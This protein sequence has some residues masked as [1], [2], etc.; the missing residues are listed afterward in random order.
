MAASTKPPGRP[1]SGGT[2]KPAAAAPPPVPVAA[3]GAAPAHTAKRARVRRPVVLRRRPRPL[4]GGPVALVRFMRANRMLN[5]RYGRLAL[6]WWVLKLRWRGRLRTDGLC[7]IAPGVKFEIGPHAQVTLGRWCWIGRGTKV[8]VH[9]GTLEIGAKTVLGEE[10]T[11]SAFQK[12]T[13]GRECII[14]DRTMFIDFDHG[15][16]EVER[17]I[18]QQGIYKRD[19]SIGH[20]VWIGYGACFLRGVTVGDNS[21]VGTS[22]VVCADVPAN[23][24]VGGV[25]AKVIRMRERPETLRWE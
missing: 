18:R 8:R 17:P 6:R 15:M 10:C 16:T 5:L 9:E 7:F 23:A 20:N 1:V 3:K 4:Q 21:V 2:G 12:I 14:A 22:A 11:I 24:V 25:P 19:V 13:I